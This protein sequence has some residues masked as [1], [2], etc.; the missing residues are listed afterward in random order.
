MSVTIPPDHDVRVE[1]L[2]KFARLILGV[3]SLCDDGVELIVHDLRSEG[4]EGS[5][6]RIVQMTLEVRRRERIAK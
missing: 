4:R 2:P 1:C 5:D 3:E 6:V